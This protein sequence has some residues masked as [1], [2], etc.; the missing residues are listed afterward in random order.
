MNR[1]QCL[2]HWN[3]AFSNQPLTGDYSEIEGKDGIFFSPSICPAATICRGVFHENSSISFEHFHVKNYQIKAAV[4]RSKAAH[5][6]SY[7]LARRQ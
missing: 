2:L 1:P 7:L 4:C 6:S 3:L 5:N